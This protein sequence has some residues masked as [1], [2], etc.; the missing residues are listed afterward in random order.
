MVNDSR[1]QRLKS[2][3]QTLLSELQT[4]TLGEG[5]RGRGRER[6]EEREREGDRQIKR[7]R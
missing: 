5:V 3:V 1:P 4:A 2:M 6:E 7:Q